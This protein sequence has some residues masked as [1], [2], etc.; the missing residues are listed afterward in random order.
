MANKVIPEMTRDEVAKNGD[1]KEG[2]TQIRLTYLIF[3]LTLYAHLLSRRPA[4]VIINGEILDVTKFAA[5]HPGGEQV[6]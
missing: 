6:F 4:L 3:W 5:A 2:Y 1:G